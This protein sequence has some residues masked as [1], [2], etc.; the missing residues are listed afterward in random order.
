MMLSP[1]AGNDTDQVRVEGTIGTFGG[2]GD[3]TLYA[4]EGLTNMMAA[5][6]S[7]VTLRVTPKVSALVVLN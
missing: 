4:S 5:L 3:D 2:E 1:A 6:A 7:T